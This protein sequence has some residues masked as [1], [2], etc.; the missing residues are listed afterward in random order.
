MPAPVRTVWRSRLLIA[1]ALATLLAAPPVAAQFLYL[2]NVQY[3]G[4]HGE[5][6]RFSSATGAL[7]DHFLTTQNSPIEAPFRLLIGPDGLLYVEDGAGVLR[8]DLRTGASL[9][10]IIATD[11]LVA[12]AIGPDGN[13]YAI[14]SSPGY[15]LR[16]FDTTGH[17]LGDLVPTGTGNL[18]TPTHL[19]FGPDGDL[20]VADAFGNRDVRRFDGKT[21]AFRGVFIPASGANRPLFLHFAPNGSLYVSQSGGP[22]QRYDATTGASLGSLAPPGEFGPIGLATGP[23]GSL[24]AVEEFGRGVARFSETTNAYLGLLIGSGASG[25]AYPRAIV[26]GPCVTGTGG[27]GSLCVNDARFRVVAHWRTPNGATGIGTPVQLTGDTGTF[28]FF[29]KKNVEAVVKVLDGCAVNNRYWVFAG[30]L[31]NVFV[32]LDVT[33]TR[34]GATKSYTNPLGK[35]FA[36]IQDTAAFAC[37]G[38]P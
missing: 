35:P 1:S 18:A 11:T 2:T 14:D 30:G 34:S 5:I 29:D 3:G 10:R 26:F 20:Y 24:Y 38:N 9:G 17:P 25:L 7:I 36:P 16:I 6:L 8:F 12:I 27:L 37:A 33:D 23:D 32:R 15:R 13:L 22:I 28:W 4:T 19:V 31:T 21:G